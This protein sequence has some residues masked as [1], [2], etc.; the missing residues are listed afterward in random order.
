[1]KI[2]RQI[3]NIG[4]LLVFLSFYAYAMD[5]AESKIQ[6]DALLEKLLEK[7]KKGGQLYCEYGSGGKHEEFNSCK[8]FLLLQKKGCFGYSTAG[9]SMK[10]WYSDLCKE[11]DTLKRAKPATTNYFKINSDDWW[12]YLPAEVIP[13]PGG[14]YNDSS[15]EI[16]KVAREK[17]VKGKLLGEIAFSKVSATKESLEAILSIDKGEC[18]EVEDFFKISIEKIADFNSDGI[19]ELL[20]KGYRVKRSDSCNLG[21]G[22][23][24]GA[25]F[26]VLVQ[27]KGAT[28]TPVIINQNME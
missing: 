12:K 6:F 24:L 4:I 27:K 17:L 14:I 10:I 25:G 8:S 13:M 28:E 7:E 26:S 2:F 21:S 3:T 15:W 16:T 23:S 9:I 5:S 19:A 20:L 11:I 22:N 1:L 18:G